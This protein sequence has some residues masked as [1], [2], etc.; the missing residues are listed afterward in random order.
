[1]I[2]PTFNNSFCVLKNRVIAGKILK[3]K[4][5]IEIPY[6]FNCNTLSPHKNIETLIAAFVNLKK[7]KKLPHKLIIAGDDRY[8]KP[9]FRSKD[10]I[11]L[12]SVSEKLLLYLYNCATLFV[13]PSLY[14]GF[15]YP[16]LEAMACGIP[17]ISSNAGSLPEVMGKGGFMFDPLDVDAL[18]DLMLSVIENNRLRQDI[19]K[20]GVTRVRC[21][22]KMDQA[23]AIVN[24]YK[25]LFKKTA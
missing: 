18:S 20:Y 6:I 9:R 13:Y 4:L 24:L 10:V 12:G 16:L 22:L 3:K 2:Y 11:F 25:K 7:R 5:N 19:I 21:F 8:Y 23:S 1:V 17:V 14:E 15:G